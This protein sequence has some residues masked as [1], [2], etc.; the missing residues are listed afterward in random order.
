M[1]GCFRRGYCGVVWVV[2]APWPPCCPHPSP[3]PPRGRGDGCCG[4]GGVSAR[5]GDG[6]CSEPMCTPTITQGAR[7]W[8]PSVERIRLSRRGRLPSTKQPRR[9]ESV[10]PGVSG[11]RWGKVPRNWSFM[12][13][14]EGAMGGWVFFEGSWSK[15]AVDWGRRVL[16]VRGLGGGLT[17]FGD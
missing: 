15:C 4:G 10:G 11:S 7:A 8:V 9:N 16:L 6:C 2:A 3:L 12:L 13:L 14:A 1:M 17:G 5:R